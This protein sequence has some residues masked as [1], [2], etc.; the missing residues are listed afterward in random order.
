MTR[1]VHHL[2][3]IGFREAVAA[4]L[5]TEREAVAEEFRW[6]LEALPY[7]SSP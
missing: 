1:S 6:A 7:R 3:N 2:P 5:E 4:F